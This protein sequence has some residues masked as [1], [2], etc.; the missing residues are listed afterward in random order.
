MNEGQKNIETCLAEEV[1][2]EVLNIG[3]NQSDVLAEQAVGKLID[4][5]TGSTH[6]AAQG[7]IVSTITELPSVYLTVIRK[8]WSAVLS[9][10]GGISL[11]DTIHGAYDYLRRMGATIT[12]NLPQT[13]RSLVN[14]DW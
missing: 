7:S 13:I 10:L 12:A 14:N 9:L 8:H 4:K 5:V 6:T 11:L 1:G 2:A 3:L